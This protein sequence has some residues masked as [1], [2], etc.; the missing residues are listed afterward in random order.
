MLI[1]LFRHICFARRI[2]SKMP[3]MCL[4]SSLSSVA[5]SMQ[6]CWKSGLVS[7]SIW[8]ISL[9]VNC[10]RFVFRNQNNQIFILF[11]IQF[12]NLFCFFNPLFF[13]LHKLLL[14]WIKKKNNFC[15]KKLTKKKNHWIFWIVCTKHVW[16]ICSR[17]FFE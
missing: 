17:L 12:S 8:H 3:G 14:V 1:L 13:T 4:T 16:N 10:I 15:E 11:Q 9:N 5:S 7:T 2:F 6:W